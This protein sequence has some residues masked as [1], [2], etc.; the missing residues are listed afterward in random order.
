V[1]NRLFS[2]NF[3]NGTLGAFSST[4]VLT[5]TGGWTPAVDQVTCFTDYSAFA[6]DP[7]SVSDQRLTL[8][9]P[10]NIPA[11][12][13]SALLL[14]SHTFG[15]EVVSGQNMD[16]GVLELST[17]GGA[18]WFDAGPYFSFGGYNGTITRTGAVCGGGI[19][20]PFTN[21]RSACVGTGTLTTGVNLT[22]FIGRSLQL[23]FRL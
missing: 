18:T 21:G 22:Q 12:Y 23:R 14:F 5:N 20:P 7:P 1:N 19:T 9:N 8:T 17:D 3:N 13:T 16:G 15:F 6:P 10:I 4:V 11:N 2:E